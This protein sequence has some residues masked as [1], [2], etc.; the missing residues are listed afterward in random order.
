MIIVFDLD[1]TLY[2]E[3]T[4]VRS[5]FKAVANYLYQT[6][7]IETPEK[8]FRDFVQAL[9][10]QGRGRV[11]DSFL[12]KYNLSKRKVIKKCLSVY[13]LHDPDIRLSVSGQSCLERLKNYPKY[14]VTDGNKI[15]QTK[16]VKSL[17]IDKYFK[18]MMITH[19][20]GLKYSKPSTY[21]FHKILQRE[22]A[23]PRDLIYVGDNPK[24]DFVNLKKDG[25]WT[26]RVMT[27]VYRDIV[28]SPKFEADYRIN[29]LDKLSIKNLNKMMGH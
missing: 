12:G 27:G 20:Y 25:F 24:K 22:N 14:L 3:I 15:V 19:N 9:E 18:Q 23:S 4:Y 16:K 8:I 5:G 21:C 7:K 28:A 26:A 29:S 6:Y 1:D 13:R 10:Q 2:E 11:F 17:K